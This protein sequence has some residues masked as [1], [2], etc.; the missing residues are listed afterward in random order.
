MKNT[1]VLLLAA[2]SALRLSAQ[3]EPQWS[4]T[5]P[6]S[7]ELA[8]ITVAAF[9]DGY[10]FAGTFTDTMSLAGH[11]LR[12][13]GGRDVFVL[14]VNKDGQ[15]L[16]AVSFGGPGD[17]TPSCMAASDSV[18]YVCGKSEC[19]AGNALF[20]RSIGPDFHPFSHVEYPYSGKMNADVIA[21]VPGSLAL[22]G[23]LRGRMALGDKVVQSGDSEHAFLAFLSETLESRSVWTSEGSGRHRLH[24]LVAD[25]SDGFVLALNVAGGTFEIPGNPTLLLEGEGIVITGIDGELSP[26]WT[27]TLR[28]DDYVEACDM[29]SHGEGFVVCANFNGT[30]ATRDSVLSSRCGLSSLVIRYV[31]SGNIDWMTRVDTDEYCRSLDVDTAG[32]LVLCTGY[33][34]G[35]LSVQGDILQKSPTREAF[36]LAFDDQGQLQWHINVEQRGPS[37]GRLLACDSISL[38]LCGDGESVSFSERYLFQEDNGEKESCDGKPTMNPCKDAEA[39]LDMESIQ[40]ASLLA[41][42]N[43]VRSLLYWRVAEVGD[44]SMELYDANGVCLVREAFRGT[45]SGCLDMSRVAAGIYTL[46]TYSNNNTCQQSI[47]KY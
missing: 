42:P 36:L 18:L 9:A 28:C 20:I 4:R 39:R 26:K 40:G 16:D 8:T 33:H 22:G 27:S 25:G 15:T 47:V 10:A 6:N 3:P 35:E 32:G 13:K 34:F 45:Q 21:K 1:A 2:F 5:L 19:S 44:W 17:D 29:A 43:P 7:S 37:G 41:F 31:R 46:K 14:H 12:S 11:V 23:S 24:S 30:L 38:L